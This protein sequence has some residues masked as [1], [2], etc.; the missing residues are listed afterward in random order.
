MKMN[1]EEEMIRRGRLRL[2]KLQDDRQNKNRLLVR[3]SQA[4]G[5]GLDAGRVH[6]IESLLAYLEDP[7]ITVAYDAFEDWYK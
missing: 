3:L 2:N 7:D 4:L 6:A 5:L 1:T